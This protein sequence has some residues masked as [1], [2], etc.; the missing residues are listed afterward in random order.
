MARPRPVL[1]GKIHF[2]TRTCAA[3][4]FLL[5]PSA[6]VNRAILYCLGLA[7]K[8]PGVNVQILWL[9]AMPITAYMTQTAPTRCFSSTSTRCSPKCSTPT[10]VAGATS[11]PTNPA[12]ATA[13]APAP[14]LP[15]APAHA[16]RKTTCHNP[17]TA[18]APP[19]AKPPRSDATPCAPTSTPTRAPREHKPRRESKVPPPKRYDL[20]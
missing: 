18:R 13:R 11:S 6:V 3:R 7:L 19:T 12:K 1:P 14:P 17:P 10:G 9:T 15:P 8:K 16:S 20:D 2:V 5:R 4:Q